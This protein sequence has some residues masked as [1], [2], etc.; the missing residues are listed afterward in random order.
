MNSSGIPDS[1][2]GYTLPGGG[3]RVLGGLLR[4]PTKHA[5]TGSMTGV[6][7]GT[8]AIESGTD[9]RHVG[10]LPG[11]QYPAAVA[12]NGDSCSACRPPCADVQRTLTYSLA[13]WASRRI[14]RMGSVYWSNPTTSCNN[15]RQCLAMERLENS[16]EIVALSHI[17]FGL[18]IESAMNRLVP[19]AGTG[20]TRSYARALTEGSL[21]FGDK[22]GRMQAGTTTEALMSSSICTLS[23][24]NES[25]RNLN[26]RQAPFSAKPIRK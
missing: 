13:S 19:C 12:G 18:A 14:L 6:P 9:F 4:R 16:P 21:L 24:A 5:L 22:L 23:A 10:V 11:W 20:G 15:F 3:C 1:E 25:W 26:T 17:L 8:R 7:K 2:S